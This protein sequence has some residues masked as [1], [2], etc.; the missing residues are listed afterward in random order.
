MYCITFYIYVRQK[1][2]YFPLFIIYLLF[3]I[4]LLLALY[5]LNK[6]IT[7]K[8]YEIITIKILYLG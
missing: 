7:F 3:F 6:F 8:Y 2:F 1:L 4:S 5:I